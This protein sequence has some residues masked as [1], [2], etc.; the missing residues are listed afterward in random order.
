MDA[1]KQAPGRLRQEDC[2]EFKASLVSIVSTRLGNTN[3]KSGSQEKR[4]KHP[5]Q[6]PI[7]NKKK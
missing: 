1:C 4:A 2:Q 7:E 5:T 6:N 3:Q